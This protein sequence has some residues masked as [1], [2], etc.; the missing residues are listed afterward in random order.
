[1]D[2]YNAGQVDEMRMALEKESP[3]W[4]MFVSLA[5]TCGL[6]RGELLGLEWKHINLDAGTVE[7]KQ[8][9]SFTKDEKYEIKEPKT[10][11]SIRTLGLPQFIIQE[12]RKYKTHCNL[13]RL[14]AADLW[15][16]GQNFFLFT[17]YQGK[18]LNPTSVKNFWQ[19][20]HVKNPQLKYIRIHDLRHTAATLLLNKGL[21]AKIIADM[22]GHASITTTMN[23]YAHTTMEAQHHAASVMDDLLGQKRPAQ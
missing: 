10:K 5:V 12:L 1:M 17:G 13:L 2:V 18:P 16:G 3:M 15:E 7:I 6:R 9:L 21:P 8:A 14:N 20:F 23:V 19:R 4:R 11:R 22:L